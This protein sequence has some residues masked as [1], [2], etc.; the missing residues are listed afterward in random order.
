[1]LNIKFTILTIL[2]VNFSDINYIQSCATITT[3][4]FQN[5]FIILNKL[6]TH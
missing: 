4:H 1:M 6:C 3:I 2:T 5:F